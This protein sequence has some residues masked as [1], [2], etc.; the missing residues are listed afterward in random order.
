MIAN[1][2][3]YCHRNNS[4]SWLLIFSIF[5]AIFF[6]YNNVDGQDIHFSQYMNSPLNLNPALTAYSRSSY[7]LT[8]N[9]R[10]QW[11]SVTVPYQNISASFEAKIIKRKKQR[12]YLGLGVIFNKDQAG[13][14]KF[15]TTQIGLSASFV[16]ALKRN[17][18]NIISIGIQS[19]YFQ[20]SI[21]YTQLHFQDSWNGI[22]SSP[23]SGNTENFSVSSYSFIDIS[24]GAHWFVQANKR[25]KFNTGIS[26]WHI[27]KPQQTLMNSDT[28]LNIKS[29]FYSEALINT[30]IPFD[31]IPSIMYSIQGPYQ[32]YLLGVKFYS[33]FH[34]N[35]KNYFALTYGIYG[36]YRDAL[37]LYLG[38]DYKNIKFAATY[39]FNLS[40]L[41][42]ASNAMGG[43]ELSVQWLIFKSKKSKKISPTPCPIF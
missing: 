8:L 24:A 18:S 39:D 5:S 6:S 2:S 9:S 4:Y 38:M 10:S 22:S 30:D 1:K 19:S 14:S 20:R 7:R 37:I 21:D 42:I 11:A 35:K 23:L 25:L 12:N 36:R 43:T 28:R 15:G 32:E 13:D 27:N 31:I 16:K 3:T 40:S 34:E 33:K 17:G 41:T 29:Q 26:V